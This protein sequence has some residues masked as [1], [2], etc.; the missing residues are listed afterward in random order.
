MAQPSSEKYNMNWPQW[1]GP[2]A[3]GYAPLSDPPI[4][5]SET[6]N[7]KWKTEI[8][9]KGH[10]TPIVWE[11]QIFINTAV[12]TDQSDREEEPAEE[13]TSGRRG[14]PGNTAGNIYDF[15]VM[16]I[17]RSDGS[18]LWK[19][20]VSEEQPA[21][22]THRTGTWASNSSVTDGEYLY[23]YFGSRGLY[24]LDFDV[25]IIW[26]KDFGQMKKK[27]DF[28]EGS[29]PALHKDKLVIIWDHEGDSYL[30]IL[31]KKTGE[32]IRKIPRDEAT[33]WSSPLVIH[34]N[35]RDQVLTN[36]TT[37]MRSYDLE[38]GEVIWEGSGMTNNVIPHPIVYDNIVYMMS[39]FRGNA[40]QAI[41]LQKAQGNITGTDAILW[42]YNQYTPYTPSALLIQDRLYFLRAN[43]GQISCLNAKNGKVNFSMQTLEGTGTVYASPV[44][45]RDR[46]YVSSESG[47]TY[48]LKDSEDFEVMAKNTLED[49]NFASF[50]IAGD[51]IF[52]RGFQYLYCISEE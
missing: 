1:R 22:A 51:E 28:G 34:V 19:T 3:T 46:L 5:W 30:Y 23:A 11:N 37:N 52:I 29:S 13:P 31:D 26:S 44:G 18:I 15:I 27:M 9:G 33:S 8:P 2:E 42:E 6:K 40:L 17:D 21:D 14:P 43:N 12:R 47:I 20:K 36:A 38:T 45:A 4:E 35:D 7:V 10:A 16:A 41:D 32:E 39:G 50:A 25:N 48:V 49:G 24:C